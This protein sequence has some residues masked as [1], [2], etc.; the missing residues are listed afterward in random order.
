M[1]PYDP[2]Q[3][4]PQRPPPPPEHSNMA[5]ASVV[6]GTIAFLAGVIPFVGFLGL[7]AILLGVVDGQGYDRPEAPRRHTL[8]KVGIILGALASVGAVIWTIVTI[9]FVSA[10]SHGSCPHL[11]AFD[12]KEY[13]L[14]ADLASGALYRGGERDDFDRLEALQLADG[15]YRLRLQNDLEEVDH[16]DSLSLLVVDGPSDAEVLPTQA[17]QLLAVAGARPPSRAV[18]GAGQDALSLLAADDGRSVGLG[19]KDASHEAWTLQFPRPAGGKGLLV[20]R[21]RNTAFAEDAFVRYLA[22][23]GQGVRPLMEMAVTN[24]EDCAC[25][26][27]YL[28]EEVGRMGM[29]LGIVAGATTT[30]L[31]LIGPATLRSTVVP[32][33]LPPGDGP[34]TVSLE[35]TPRFWEID[36]VLLGSEAAAP[37]VRTLAPAAATTHDGKDVL[38]L[39]VKNDEQRVALR[40]GEH[41]EILFDAPPLAE[42]KRRTVVARLR[43]YYDLDIGG[44]KGIDVGRMIAHRLGWVSLPEFAKTL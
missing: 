32:I 27:K 18:D 33:E 40:R 43:G 15:K 30:S 7:V 28:D 13:R 14:D 22:K 8:A 19:K 5:I 23:M 10:A 39:L 12:G 34:V 25:Y 26:R 4:P 35:A 20:V 3:Q 21:A 38:G 44:R 36:Q 42:S 16:V 37:E 24:Y 29:P 17:G 41:V 31:K 1:N 2:Y 6:V 9:W 11:Y